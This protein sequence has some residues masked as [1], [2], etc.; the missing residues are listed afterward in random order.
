MLTLTIT[1]C[2]DNPPVLSPSGY[3]FTIPERT[4]GPSADEQVFT[5]VSA[6]DSDATAANRA[7][8]YSVVG[9]VASANNWFD[10]T[11]AT[12]S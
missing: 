4:T 3:A 12:V 11:S 1:D 8:A 6:T 7:T 9:G 2:N 5:G 10:I